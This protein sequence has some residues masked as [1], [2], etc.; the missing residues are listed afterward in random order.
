MTIIELEQIEE[1]AQRGLPVAPEDI[2]ILTA[3]LRDVLQAKATAEA[4]AFEALKK[5]GLNSR[6]YT[7]G[8]RQAS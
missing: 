5:A 1:R 7:A 4:V 3:Y 6:Y 8:M 2:L